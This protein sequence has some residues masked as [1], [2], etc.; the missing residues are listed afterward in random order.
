M[1]NVFD[2]IAGPANAATATSSIFT[3]TTAHIYVIKNIRFVNNSAS[4]ITVKFG[5][6][7]TADANLI[8]PAV[9]V[10]AGGMLNHDCFVIL[11][12]TEVLHINVSAT[13][14]TYTV[15]AVDIG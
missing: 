10:P 3:G 5:I 14:G 13:G 1:A 8:I 12:G 9:S 6:G 2:R 11:E 15:S 4:A 7:G